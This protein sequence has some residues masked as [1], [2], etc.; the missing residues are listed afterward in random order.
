MRALGNLAVTVGTRHVR[1]GIRL[2]HELVELERRMGVRSGLTMMN[3]TEIARWAGEWDWADELQSELLASDLEGV[4][5]LFA[6]GIDV[7]FKAA[8]GE[9]RGGEHEELDRLAAGAG[10]SGALVIAMGIR[11][12]MY[13]YAGR[14]R[15]ALVEAESQARSDS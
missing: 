9:L 10:R 6:L 14:F 3:A 1:E 5:R 8:R 4:D 13:L 15:E 11:P 12:E 7:I 2:T